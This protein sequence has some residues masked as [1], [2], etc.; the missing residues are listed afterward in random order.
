M[1]IFESKKFGNFNAEY[2]YKATGDEIFVWMIA[3]QH[4]DG[5]WDALSK[6]L[7]VECE[8][9]EEQVRKIVKDHQSYERAVRRG[10]DG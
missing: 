4:R 1:N 5:S 6:P 7:M 10:F 3:V 9:L 8:E 2:E